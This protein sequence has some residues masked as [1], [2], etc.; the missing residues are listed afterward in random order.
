MM[1]ESNEILEYDGTFDGFLCCVATIFREKRRPHQLLSTAEISQTLFL[2]RYI[3]RDRQL[4]IRIKTRLKQRLTTDS[5]EFIEKGFAS[6]VENRETALIVAIEFGLHFGDNLSRHTYQ[7]EIEALYIGIR[8][9]NVEIHHYQGFTRFNEVDGWLIAVIDPK[10][11][12]LPYLMPFF[13]QRFPN[14][15]FAICEQK[16]Q[17]VG[18]YNQGQISFNP[19]QKVPELNLSPEELAIQEQWRTFFQTVAIEERK[20]PTCQR[21]HL[22]KRFWKY[23]PEMTENK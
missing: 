16:S 4:A 22:P 11:G 21:N 6:V 13:C 5:W 1:P 15:R 20:N 7:K 18:S 14:E 23:L 3:N 8:Q 10:H 17:M 19:L 12:V 9:L 2:G